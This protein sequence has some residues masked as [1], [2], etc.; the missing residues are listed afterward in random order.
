MRGAAAAPGVAVEIFEELQTVAEM[1]IVV[2]ARRLGLIGPPPARVLEEQRL[3]TARQFV[4]DLV[5][6][7]IIL[8]AGRA[9]DAELVAD[10]SDEVCAAIWISRKLIGAQTG[11]RQLELPP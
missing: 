7:Q 8:R 6:R 9:F 1:R 10:N 5:Q 2:E 11:P 3:E 4:G